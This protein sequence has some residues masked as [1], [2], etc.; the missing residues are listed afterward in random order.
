L[1]TGTLSIEDFVMRA[2]FFALLSLALVQPAGGGEKSSPEALAKKVAPFVDDMTILVVHVDL[3]RLD[4]AAIFKLLGALGLKDETEGAKTAALKMQEGLK[5]LDALD[6]FV[7]LNWDA[8][9]LDHDFLFVI[10][11]PEKA[12]EIPDASKALGLP[13]R[14]IVKEGAL[15]LSTPDNLERMKDFK[16]SARPAL[17]KALAAFADTDAKALLLP[18][19][20]LLRTLVE[21]FPKLPVGLGDGGTRDLAHGF[22]WAGFGVHTKDKVE[23]RLIIQAGDAKSAERL[24]TLAKKALDIPLHHPEIQLIF[25][26]FLKMRDRLVPE[27][28][29]DQLVLEITPALLRDIIGPAAGKVRAAAARSQ[30]VNNLKQIGLA[31]HN[32]HDTHKA[33]PPAAFRSKEGKPLLSWRVHLLPYLEGGALYREFKLDEAWDS[34]HNKKLIDK[35][36]AVYASPLQRDLRPGKTTYL[37]PSGPGTAFADPKGTHLKNF[38][39]GTSNTILAFE[40]SAKKAV[41]WTQPDDFPADQKDLLAG[42]VHPELKGFPALFADGS[43]RWISGS[44]RLETLRALITPSGGEV[45]PWDEVK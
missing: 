8:P 40:V 26:E 4:V 38:A 11:L 16:P 2:A 24:Q 37:V 12:G 21:L 25:P 28:K 23:A 44:I 17:V 15:L 36:P 19:P 6:V 41:F 27:R 22:A 3:Q 13:W 42:L 29:G 9:R 10:P 34:P 20:V 33:F 7:V 30:S 31:F 45:V 43:V 1:K 39:D 14:S 18:P 35:M 32:Y 5:A